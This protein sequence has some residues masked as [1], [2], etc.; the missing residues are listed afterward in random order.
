[1]HGSLG[2]RMQYLS[3]MTPLVVP[4]R[5]SPSAHVI[6]AADPALGSDR[7]I[8]PGDFSGLR[9]EFHDEMF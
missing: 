8:Y 6:Y 1:M 2:I 4:L 3:R 5:R 9:S 7:L